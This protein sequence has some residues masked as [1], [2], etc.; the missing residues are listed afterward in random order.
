MFMFPNVWR[1]AGSV[2]TLAFAGCAPQI[3]NMNDF[4][5]HCAYVPPPP[6][7]GRWRLGKLVAGNITFS[8][9]VYP[10]WFHRLMQRL[11]LGIY[12]ERA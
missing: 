9:S 3:S 4:Y 10:G 12:W 6:V 8:Q 1:A 11:I 7:R 5:A 2:K